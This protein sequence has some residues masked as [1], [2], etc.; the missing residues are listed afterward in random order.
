MDSKKINQLATN[1]APSVYDLTVVGDATTGEL[2]KITLN[3][4]ASLF[5]SVGGVSSVSMTV[6][7]GL[8]IS[9]SPITTSGTL[10]V[11]FTAGYSIPTN[12][13]Q[14][15]WDLGY[16]ERLKW[17]GG[18]AGLVASTARAS[19]GLVIGTDVLAYR[20]FGSAAN[21]AT[22]DFAT[23]AQGVSADTAYS[24]RLTGA[25]LPLSISSNV[26]S[27]TQAST[28]TNG[29]LSSTDWNTFNG[30]QAAL[31]FTPY[32]ATN[33]AGYLSSV[34]LTTNV[35]GVLPIAN[36][37][38]GA[39]TA[40]GART[41]L[42][43]A[44]GSDVL[45]YRTFGSAAN[46]NTSD[47]YANSNPNSYISGITSL[48]VTN[49]LGFTPYSA[50]NP[51]GYTSNTGTVTSVSGTG[52]VSGLTLTG[53]FSTSGTL[54]LGGTLSLTSLNVTNALGF[55]PYNSTNPS[56]YITSSAL[57]PYQLQLN[58]TGFVKA[59]GTTISYDNS[60]YLTTS[61][62]SSTYLPLSGGTLTGPLNGT[63]GLFSNSLTAQNMYSVSD[64]SEQ[65]TI[66]TAA[67][68]NKQLI[69]G[70]TTT[71][72]KIIAVTQGVGYVPLCLQPAGGNVGIGLISP[73]ST[74]DVLQQI[75]VSYANANQYRVRITNTDGNGR[76]LVDGSASSLIFGTS[77]SGVGATA[78]EYM[79]LTPSGRLLLGTPTEATYMLD[80]NGTGR[81]SGDLRAS[82]LTLRD[83]G[84][85][86]FSTA[87]D[88]GGISV[89]YFGYNTGTTY[90]RDFTVF[91]GKNAQLF[92][93]TGST[94]AALFASSVTATS[95][96]ESSDSRL[97]TLIQ[98]NYQTKG[99]AS[100]TPKLY[101]KNGKV[102]LGYYAQDFIGVLDSA[103]VK[104]EDD[105]L[106]LSYRE[107][108]V[109]KVY[110]LEQRIKELENK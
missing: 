102:E 96:F 4:I 39:T 6:P 63:S 30:K 27:I 110:A 84:I 18:S 13:K 11:T 62:A 50:A 23:F 82:K 14:S 58:G 70:R 31:G 16:A 94:S 74:L 20:T 32:N 72:A 2:K 43:I 8:T 1:V 21:N 92:K 45:A 40:S 47:F 65:I 83:D 26:I 12:A 95:F 75:R 105:M 48:M 86:N 3:Q 101:T 38:T 80:V 89:N 97:K 88:T 5:G 17:D 24:L 44:I 98:D 76:I 69:F 64:N 73:A 25:S 59:S 90:Y 53:S 109:A 19:L 35:T 104:R 37:G 79:T 61:S 41:N 107:V 78:T 9:G 54:T 99:I 33:P 68:N 15:E 106:S 55:T 87:S 22:A 71:E 49:A 28:S 34:S 81:F 10:A 52:S 103:V 93:L 56:G 29:Y 51:S 36:G 66:K 67:D 77:A 100:I 91:N 42:G 85:E 57:T 108:L 46:N 60:T 7:T